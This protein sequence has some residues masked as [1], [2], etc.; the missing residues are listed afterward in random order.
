MRRKGWMGAALAAVVVLSL[1]YARFAS[2]Q[3]YRESVS[4]LEEVYGQVNAALRSTISKNWRLLRSWQPY[5]AAETDPA[6]LAD[7]LLE[8]G[9]AWH[10]TA[11][12]FLAPDGSYVTGQGETGRMALAGLDLSDTASEVQSPDGRRLALFTVP[13]E[14]GTY[15]GFDYAAVGFAFPAEDMSG[16]LRVE[17]FSDQSRCF[18]V[19]PGGQ[20]LFSSHSGPDAPSNLLDDLRR[21]GSFSGM[22][23]EDVARDWQRGERLTTMCRLDGRAHY[24]TYQPVGFSGWMLVSAAPA[25]VVNAGMSRFS[26]VTLTVMALLFGILALGAVAASVHTSRRRVWEQDREIRSREELFDL[27][28]ENTEDIFVLFSPQ[29]GFHAQYVSPNLDRVLGMD[30]EEVRADVRAILFGGQEERFSSSPSQL[31]AEVLSSVPV[32]GMWTGERDVLHARTQELRRF[33]QLLHHCTLEDKDQFILMLSDRTQER[34]MYEALGEALHTAKAA[35]EAKSNFLANMS[36]DIR[37]PMNAIVGF[38]VLLGRDAEHPEKVREYTRKISSS[39]QH[40]LNLINDILDMSK[41]ESGKTSLN[42]SEFSLPQLVDD[43]YAMMLPQARAKSQRFALHTRGSLPELLLG[44]KLR[45]NQVLIN[46]LSNAVKYTQ[47]GGQISLTLQG[48]GACAPGRAR[49]RFIV[50]DNGYGMS[51]TFMQTIFDPF[52]REITDA[53]REIQGTGLGMAITKNIVDLMG[54]SICVESELGQGATFTLDLELAAAD[55]ARDDSFWLR[56]GITRLLVA[57]G[58]EAAC[59]SVRSALEEAGLEAVCAASGPQAVALAERAAAQG[60]PFHLILLDWRLPGM[61]GLEAAR[62]IRRTAGPQPPLLVLTSFDLDEAR[63]AGQSME[64]DLFLP[65]PFFLS[66]LQRAAAQLLEPEPGPQEAPEQEEASLE[67]LR[68]LAA[69][70]NEINAEILVELLEMEG[71]ACQVVPNGREAV[72][73]FAASQPGEFDMIFMD[74]QMPV[75]DGYDATRAIRGSGHPLADVIPIIAMTANAFEEDVQTALAAGMDAHTAKPID[76]SRLR[77]VISL[78]RRPGYARVQP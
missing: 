76:M 55:Q 45:L 2:R 61:D 75:M 53:T 43:L 68:I 37:T 6:A 31:T 78:L 20:V 39:S 13:A 67:G 49:L 64:I 65:K 26:L 69:E 63:H 44:D 38:S 15:R 52:A 17:T 70:D 3:I 29:E 28:T 46:L 19:L 60:R 59:Q 40:L 23:P 16:G 8:E 48:L 9:E 14:P 42:V 21:R 62:R 12:Y 71:A 47:P 54:G 51:E 24:L 35:N 22:E 30:P 25:D 58:E 50:A 7:F 27:L 77:A 41:I 66:R 33:K 36:H 5:I 4:R 57:D 10:F 18:V 56:H 73:L 1:F 32:G 34:Q 72:S 11:F 74:V